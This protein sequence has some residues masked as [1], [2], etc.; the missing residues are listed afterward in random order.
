MGSTPQAS[1]L[2]IHAR[3]SVGVPFFE[4]GMLR[5][6]P[7]YPQTVDQEIG[8]S[9]VGIFR[10]DIIHTAKLVQF[11]AGV[12]TF[13]FCQVE[14]HLLGSE[15]SEKAYRLTEI[16]PLHMREEPPISE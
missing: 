9:E 1:K 7:L 14:D 15:W 5:C 6:H 3:Y 12:A 16:I 13:Y 11:L 10:V 4:A 8:K 2:L